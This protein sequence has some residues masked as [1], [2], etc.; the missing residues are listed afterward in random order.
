[1][2]P[3]DE[4][5]PPDG[6]SE[7]G[8][9][10][11]ASEGASDIVEWALISDVGAE[12]ESN[13]DFAGTDVPSGSGPPLF[14]VA[15]G[16]GGHAAGEVASRL[17]VETMVADWASESGAAHQRLRAAARAANRSEERRVGKECRSRW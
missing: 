4:A 13:E 9:G 14:V 8:N 12:R 11:L 15:D 7:A 2:C 5:A 3:A 10:Q 17:A 1:M 6:P 16:M